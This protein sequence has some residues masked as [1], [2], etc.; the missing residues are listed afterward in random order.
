MAKSLL[1][2]P[3]AL[4]SGF[5]A[6]CLQRIKDLAAD[7]ATLLDRLEQRNAASFSRLEETLQALELDRAMESMEQSAALIVV[8]ES[9]LRSALRNLLDALYI[10]P[11]T[12]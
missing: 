8:A 4:E 2:A 5:E 3:R 7:G 1:P 11:E 9:E 10:T 6:G 12:R